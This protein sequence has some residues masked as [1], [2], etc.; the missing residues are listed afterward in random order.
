M[1]RRYN[2]K[3]LDLSGGKEVAILEA[4]TLTMKDLEDIFGLEESRSR[5]LFTIDEKDMLMLP[6]MVGMI[7][8]SLT[9]LNL[10]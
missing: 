7:I 3:P 8:V 2:K 6:W 4:E 9:F 1:L 10:C 5:T